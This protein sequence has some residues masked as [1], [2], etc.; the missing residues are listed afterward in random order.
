MNGVMSL[1]HTKKV[2]KGNDRVIVSST[3][4]NN[5]IVNLRH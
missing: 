2:Q 3:Y 1:D 5:R 4:A